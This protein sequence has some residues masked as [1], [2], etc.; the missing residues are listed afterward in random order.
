[1]RCQGGYRKRHA[2]S[3]TVLAGDCAL[4]EIKTFSVCSYRFLPLFTSRSQSGQHV[5]FC[6]EDG[7]PRT[8]F[9][10]AAAISLFSCR[11]RGG[12]EYRDAVA[13]SNAS[14]VYHVLKRNSVRDCSFGRDD[15]PMVK[16]DSLTCLFHCSVWGCVGQ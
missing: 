11:D 15:I 14:V 3:G 9:L 12:T 8:V 13:A 2:S 16:L 7:R 10:Q 4:G 1:M 6:G 5:R